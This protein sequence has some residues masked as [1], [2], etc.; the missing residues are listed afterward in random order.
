MKQVDPMHEIV[1]KPEDFK[2]AVITIP[3]DEDYPDIFKTSTPGK[4]IWRSSDGIEYPAG[5]VAYAINT[6]IWAIGGVFK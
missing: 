2:N 3:L 6:F 5:Q 4:L 1:M